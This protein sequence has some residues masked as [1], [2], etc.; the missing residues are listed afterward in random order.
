MIATEQMKALPA[1]T[2]STD[3]TWMPGR[4]TVTLYEIVVTDG[5]RI[6]LLGYWVRSRRRIVDALYKYVDLLKELTGEEDAYAAGT[7]GR[8][9]YHVKMGEWQLRFSGRTEREARGLAYPFIADN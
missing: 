8:G 9:D 1:P 7:W 2:I 3:Q 6:F 4:N 5:E